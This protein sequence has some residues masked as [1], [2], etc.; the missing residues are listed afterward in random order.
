[1]KIKK[2]IAYLEELAPLKY[3]ESYDNAGYIVGNGEEDLTGYITCLDSTE[4]VV[5][6]A[7]EKRCNLII[8]IW[9]NA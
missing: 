7:I 1:M 3:Q 9:F 5:D 4:E 2:M 8:R 6:E